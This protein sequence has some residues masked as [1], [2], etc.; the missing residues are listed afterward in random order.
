MGCSTFTHTPRK[1]LSSAEPVDEALNASRIAMNQCFFLGPALL[2]DA[3]RQSVCREFRTTGGEEFMQFVCLYESR[4]H[5]LYRTEFL[6]YETSPGAGLISPLRG[7]DMQEMESDV[8]ICSHWETLPEMF[9]KCGEK[10]TSRVLTLAY[11]IPWRCSGVS[12]SANEW[13]TM[14]LGAMS[15]QSLPLL[16][17]ELGLEPRGLLENESRA[18]GGEEHPAGGEYDMCGPAW[19]IDRD[20]DEC[21]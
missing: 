11:I 10:K 5:D 14:V 6:K 16:L 3:L 13:C 2:R 17:Q 9:L 12:H 7:S 1:H 8:A 4:L 20:F 18:E 15:V 21:I 19:S